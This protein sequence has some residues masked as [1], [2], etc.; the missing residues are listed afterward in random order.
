[1]S[2]DNQ[3][4]DQSNSQ[5]NIKTAKQIMDKCES[6]LKIQLNKF[7]E[8]YSYSDKQELK[9]IED[10]DAFH[11]YIKDYESHLEHKLKAYKDRIASFSRIL[12][13]QFNK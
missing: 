1:M 11:L 7:S 12:N 3:S 4:S 8:E 10:L 5:M 6:A 13:I 2:N 9:A